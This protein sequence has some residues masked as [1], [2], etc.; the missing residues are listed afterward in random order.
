MTT[1]GFYP[2]GWV[3]LVLEK[4]Y[5]VKSQQKAQKHRA[6]FPQIQ[7]FTGFSNAIFAKIYIDEERRKF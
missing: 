3:N 4:T 6:S 5:G 1:K 2:A 7:S